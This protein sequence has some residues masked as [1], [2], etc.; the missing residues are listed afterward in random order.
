[1][2]ATANVLVA[3]NPADGSEIGR[4]PATDPSAVAAAMGGARR[5]QS[6]WGAL[7]LRDRREVIARWWALFAGRADELAVAIRDEI[8]KPIDEARAEVITALDL[9]RWTVN[10]GVRALA[11]R[12]IGPGWQRWMMMPAGRLEWRPVGVVALIGTWNYPVYLTAPTIAQALF[13]GNAVVWKPSELAVWTGQIVQ[14]TFDDAGLPPGLVAAVP[15]GPDI[16]RA[17]VEAGPDLGHFTG[18]VE[19]G[20]RVAAALADRGAPM[21]AELSGFDAAIVRR[22]AP[23]DATARALAWSAFVGCGQTCI[24][25]K[26]VYVVGEA[27]PWPEALGAVARSLR[28]GDPRGGDVDVGPMISESARD[29]FAATIAAAVAAGARV[30]AGAEPVPGPGWFTRPTVLSAVDDRAERAL[31]GCFGPVVVVRAVPDDDAAVAAAN[32]SRFALA[33]SVWGLDRHAARRVAGRLRAG[34]VAVNDAVTPSAH[35]AA[36]FGG[37][38]ASGW[39]RTHGVEGLRSFA[40]PVVIHSRS[41]GGWRPHLFPYDGRLA[42]SLDLYRRLFHGRGPGPR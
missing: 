10:H 8:G 22:D 37:F 35:A 23:L 11:G 32:G 17:L 39:G 16:G 5:A 24:A 6:D 12:R 41:A 28:V 34:M 31:E 19:N 33:A 38:G 25:V 4:V 27:T 14:R 40:A 13:A 9:V 2:S 21:I 3:R 18:G 7:P 15:G 36:P 1:M 42:R 29:R 26:R 20:R 30:V